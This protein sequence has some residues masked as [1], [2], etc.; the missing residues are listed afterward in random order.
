MKKLLLIAILGINGLVFGLNRHAIDIL[1][2]TKACHH[3]NL[4]K[5]DLSGLNL[6]N[7]KLFMSVF[8]NTNLA[9]TNLESAQLQKA[10]FK[11]NIIAT[12]ANFNNADLSE[13]VIY[14]DAL[15]VPD[16]KGNFPKFTN[17]KFYN[18]EIPKEFIFLHQAGIIKPNFTGAKIRRGLFPHSFITCENRMCSNI[19]LKDLFAY[20]HEQG[21]VSNKYVNTIIELY[22]KIY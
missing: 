13:A 9:N 5:T 11:N 2:E 22:K 21:H 15:V 12:K 20:T 18:A 4:T 8:D 7:A 6:S 14:D 1:K 17:T 16:G 10:I 3:C 19:K